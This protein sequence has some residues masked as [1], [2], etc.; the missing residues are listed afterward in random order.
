MCRL[1]SVAD[2]LPDRRRHGNSRGN[3]S[4][5]ALCIPSVP[6]ILAFLSVQVV[7]SGRRIYALLIRRFRVRAPDAPP[8]LTCDNLVQV[9]PRSGVSWKQ[10]IRF[11][12][13]QN[14]Q[15]AQDV[16]TFGNAWLRDEPA[17]APRVRQA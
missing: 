5:S 7:H 1:R 11:F 6:S 10:L 9:A 17:S 8:G 3:T 2:E 12:G 13:A 4:L 16:V 14:V 15:N